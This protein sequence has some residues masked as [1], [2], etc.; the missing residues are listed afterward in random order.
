MFEKRGQ[1]QNNHYS[2]EIYQRYETSKIEDYEFEV[3]IT[4]QILN[5]IYTCIEIQNSEAFYLYYKTEKFFYDSDFYPEY[6]KVNACQRMVKN[7]QTISAIRSATNL[8]EH[9]EKKLNLNGFP[10]F[11]KMDLIS[12]SE[13]ATEIN[14]KDKNCHLKFEILNALIE[15]RDAL[16][17]KYPPA[18]KGEIKDKTYI[19]VFNSMMTELFSKNIWIQKIINL[20]IKTADQWID[21]DINLPTSYRRQKSKETT[22]SMRAL[23]IQIL[24]TD[25][26]VIA[27]P[28]LIFSDKFLNE[29]RAQYPDY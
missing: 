21:F 18:K 15:L 17:E 13:L 22:S 1:G 25:E 24:A 20:Q 5:S 28:S 29:K 9:L 7:I 12:I 23:L 26:R 2:Y 14:D 10:N 16:K 19:T 3:L 6:M 4:D 8:K 11:T 27:E